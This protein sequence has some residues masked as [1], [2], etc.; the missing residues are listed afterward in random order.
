M[1]FANISNEIIEGFKKAVEKLIERAIKDEREAG[2]SE[3]DESKI[4]KAK[5]LLKDK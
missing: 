3:K 5:D 4:M 1:L 2:I